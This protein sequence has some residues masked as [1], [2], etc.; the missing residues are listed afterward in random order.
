MIGSRFIHNNCSHFYSVQEGPYRGSCGEGFE[1]NSG[2]GFGS[3]LDIDYPPA[4]IEAHNYCSR[5]GL[6]V[7]IASACLG[8]AFEAYDRGDLSREEANGLDLIWGNH[9]AAIELLHALVER[10]GIGDM[11]AEGVKSA[12]ET[13]GRGSEAYALQVKGADLNEAAMRPM[14]AWALGIVLSTHGGG[15]LDG[16]PGAWAWVGQEELAK[17]LFGNPHPGAAGDYRNQAA[18]VIWFEN[19]KA[20][21]DML[22]ICYFTSMWIDSQALSADDYADL[23]SAGSGRHFTGEE[24]M[25]LGRNLHQVQKAFNTLHTGFTRVDDHPPQ[26]LLEP[27]KSGP[28]SGERLDPEKWEDMLDEYYRMNHWDLATGWQTAESLRVT[29]LNE[30]AAKLKANGRLKL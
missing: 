21:I 22:G 27:A 8:F 25:H 18:V 4:I 19:Y 11:L 13:L 10:R 29:G 15:H 23:L 3:N 24:L 17:E 26:R 5:M 20:V 12:S 14:K 6:D 7:D 2:R 30:V 9:E 1:I 16:A 28:F